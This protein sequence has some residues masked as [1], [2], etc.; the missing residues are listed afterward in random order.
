[1]NFAPARPRRRTAENFV[2]MINVV[3]LLLIFFLMSASIAPPDPF[4]TSPPSSAADA[5]PDPD[6]LYVGQTGQL[7]YEGQTDA[8][9]LVALRHRDQ[10]MPLT[11]RADAALP[12]NT[13][14]ALLPKL[15]TAGVRDTMLIT[16]RP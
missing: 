10:D 13:L 4:D 14:A 15:A 12:A 5:T 3:F 11:I 7:S 1:M 16:G 8:T 6:T 2:P 9:A